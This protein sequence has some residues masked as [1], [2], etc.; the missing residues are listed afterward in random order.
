MK[1]VFLIL[2]ILLS[3]CVPRTSA[4][5]EISFLVERTDSL[6]VGEVCISEPA[7]E[8]NV[9][10]N[11]SVNQQTFSL[12]TFP[13][14]CQSF[15]FISIEPVV[16]TASGFIVGEGFFRSTFNETCKLF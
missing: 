2:I 15:E 3:A 13:A 7:T 14:G 11:S 1:K 5:F 4:D 10:F 6:I 12:P 16:C 9:N 8:V